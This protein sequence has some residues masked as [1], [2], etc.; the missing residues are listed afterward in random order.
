MA[1]IKC[2][3]C[4]QE[5]S[6]KSIK[7]ISCGNRLQKRKIEYKSILIIGIICIFVIIIAFVIKFL[8]GNKTDTVVNPNPDGTFMNIIYELR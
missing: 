6:D 5:I 1:L 3:K 8:I 2:K 7:C 4:G